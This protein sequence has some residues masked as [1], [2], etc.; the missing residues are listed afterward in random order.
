MSIEPKLRVVVPR[1]VG[2]PRPSS[3]TIRTF[4]RGRFA[5]SLVL[6]N[7]P[8]VSDKDRGI[9]DTIAR[10]IAWLTLGRFKPTFRCGCARRRAWL[11]RVVPYSW[12]GSS[13]PGG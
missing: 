4:A 12:S 5:V 10:A 3:E 8:F 2:P 11:N 6:L 9:G 7:P 1:R 13:H